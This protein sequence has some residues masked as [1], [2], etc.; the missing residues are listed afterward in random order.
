MRNVVI[1]GIGPVTPI[2]IGKQEF[3]Q[4]LVDAKSNYSAITRFELQDYDKIRIAAQI[5]NFNIRDH[6]DIPTYKA[7]EKLNSPNA[8]LAIS[9]LLAAARLAIQDS[10]INLKESDKQRIGTIIGSGLGDLG[11]IQSQNIN[12]TRSAL[13]LPSSLSSLVSREFQINGVSRVSSAACASGN[14]A[15]EEG[16]EKIKNSTHDIMIVGSCESPI[17]TPY[18]YGNKKD[19]TKGTKGLSIANDLENGMIPFDKERVGPVLSEGAGVLI[20]EEEE[21]ALKRGA[22]IYAQIISTGNYTCFDTNLLRITKQ[23][24]YNSM[25]LALQRANL[26]P[27]LG[28]YVNAHGTSSI[29]NDKFESLAIN[30]LLGNKTLTSSFKGTL[31]HSQAASSSIELIGCVL[32]LKKEIIPKTNLK[33]VAGDCADLDYVKEKRSLDSDYI[34]KNAAGFGGLY[35]TIILGK[36]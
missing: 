12:F 32:A 9:F 18:F 1:T 35:S 34:I 21:H 24:Y 6:L 5:P 16:Y 17:G 2:G 25:Q 26:G 11:I 15:L 8:G 36:Y 20:L 19:R 13:A 4:S 29:M 22:K 10:N 14:I 33:Q 31:G 28:F 23:G 3:W 27:N 30:Q 7:I